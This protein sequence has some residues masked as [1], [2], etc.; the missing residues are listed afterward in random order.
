MTSKASTCHVVITVFLNLVLFEHEIIVFA[1]VIL[2][3]IMG[4]SNDQP[5][6]VLHN[7]SPA[8]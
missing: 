6:S 8:V 7:S 1:S 3:A 5:L 2:G 4:V